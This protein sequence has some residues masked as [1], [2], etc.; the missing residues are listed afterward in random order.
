MTVAELAGVGATRARIESV[1][2]HDAVPDHLRVAVLLGAFAGLRIAEVCGLRV[3][4]VD[5]IRGV[6]YPKQQFLNR[7][8][9]A[10]LAPLKTEGSSQPIPIPRDLA[11]LLSASVQKYPSDMMVTPG[12]GTN[13]CS[14]WVIEQAMRNVRG[15]VDGL[16]DT[17]TFCGTIW[18]RC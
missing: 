1:A 18:R 9:P 16:P 4:D 13:R 10:R 6:V 2:I 5:F 11:L 12:P 17:F 14:V 7:G 15:R 3:T 8:G